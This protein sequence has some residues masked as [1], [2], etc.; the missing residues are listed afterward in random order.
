MSTNTNRWNT[1]TPM[2]TTN[3]TGMTT[4]DPWSSRTRIA[5]AMP[6]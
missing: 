5:I 2:C 3:I 6:G 4:R 1:S